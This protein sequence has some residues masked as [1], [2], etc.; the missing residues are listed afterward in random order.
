MGIFTKAVK[1]IVENQ[2]SKIK[3]S[4][5]INPLVKQ[6]EDIF[7][8]PDQVGDPMLDDTISLLSETNQKYV[9]EEKIGLEK[10]EIVGRLYSPV[11]S[12]IENM[13]IGKGGTKGEN[14][15]AYLRKRAPNV[16]KTE[17]ESFDINLDPKRLYTKEEVLDLAKEKGSTD[18]TIEKQ[19]FPE[20]R[21]SQRQDVMD[22][23]ED[24]LELTVEGKQKY[25]ESSSAVHLGRKSNIGHSRSSIR[26][27]APTQLQQKIIDRPRYLLIEEIQSDLAKRRGKDGYIEGIEF[28]PDEEDYDE[29]ILSFDNESMYTGINYNVY[30]DSNVEEIIRLEITNNFSPFNVNTVDDIKLI[31]E[32][33]TYIGLFKD[34]IEKQTGKRP[35]GNTLIKAARNALIDSSDFSDAKVDDALVNAQGSADPE[36]Q[37]VNDI[38]RLFNELPEKLV[39]VYSGQKEN[40]ASIQKIPVDSRSGYVR[41]LILA[42]IA[43]AKRNG[44]DKIVIPN[45]R[46]IAKM[47]IET[48]DSVLASD[49]Q[50]FKAYEKARKKKGF[51]YDEYAADYFEK[52]FKPLYKDSVTKVLN[53]L[54]S[55][56]K[57]KIKYGTKELKYRGP[58]KEDAQG[59]LTNTRLPYKADAIEIDITDFE[60]NP[61]AQSLRFNEGGAVSMQEQMKLFNEGGLKDEGGSV[62]PVSGNDV[63]IGS[64]QE[65]VRDDIP[66]MLS[67]G[68]FVFPADVVR[69]L[70]LERLMQLRQE[71]KMGL[72]QMEAMG[73]M[74]NSEEATMPDDLPFNMADLI[75][76]AGEG[77]EPKEMAQGG[78][79]HMSNGG[80]LPKFVDQGVETAPINIESF[81]TTLPDPDFSNVKKYVNKEGKVRFIP[82]GP[83]GKPLYPI[84]VGFFPEGELPED[85]PTETEEAIPTTPTGGG[86]GS[87]QTRFSPFQEAGSWNM[88]TSTEAGMQMW[89]DEANKISTFGNIG[90]GVVAA[91]NPM[92]GAAFAGFN[93]MQKNKVISMLDDKIGSAQSQAQIDELNKIKTRLTTKEGKGIIAQAISGFIKPIAEALGIGEKEEVVKKVIEVT[94]NDEGKSSDDIKTEVE[95]VSK[96]AF[97]SGRLDIDT[98]P[99]AE[100][101][102]SAFPS[103]RLD[104][105]TP[106]PVSES[107]APPVDRSGAQTGLP[108]VDTRQNLISDRSGIQTGL[109]RT[110]APKADEVFDPTVQSQSVRDE[111][112]QT[113]AYSGSGYKGY[114]QINEGIIKP[115]AN[116]LQINERGTTNAYESLM[117]FI[118][119]YTS[120]APELSSLIAQ[121]QRAEDS[122]ANLDFTGTMQP[123]SGQDL[124][125]EGDIERYLSSVSDD[126]PKK[127]TSAKD[128][129]DRRQNQ[130]RFK[131]AATKALREDAIGGGSF[132]V[133]KDAYDSGAS[134]ERLQSIAKEDKKIKEKLKDMEKGI[135]TGFAKGGLASR[136]K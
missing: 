34:R 119:Q 111:G 91:L 3:P 96:S 94:N 128:R 6:T 72:K 39:K 50:L 20:Y 135:I 61:E 43:Y 41:K 121:K 62:D 110:I 84:P 55:E 129:R 19:Q 46:E 131:D 136:T 87:R 45:P 77:E 118:K 69:Y 71:A 98:P 86:G 81:D 14:I 97:P 59:R 35:E 134:S 92:L 13:A 51:N 108:R 64:T 25:T 76:V 38:D 93:K 104:I 67:E 78:V 8:S 58:Y 29:L 57:G 124:P 120:D 10:E 123:F 68:E 133:F 48:F 47:R 102:K 18:Y 32:D 122:D 33:E 112:L 105:D 42:N 40:T 85:T 65:E 2:T 36:G 5:D 7:K 4:K 80:Y 130:K 126:K 31:N 132:K 17:L 56:T 107:K 63:P 99:Q 26:R 117:N 100:D 15:S 44:I 113:E 95:Q 127:D 73:Q 54:K 37:F 115:L 83:D 101:S 89:I 74:G 16:D 60:F 1:N 9:D 90:T 24:Y 52:I 88:D 70:G 11:Y 30:T 53:T 125:T 12:A 66:A 116:A 114:D 28:N 103:G 82:F 106:P 75:I 22:A 49:Q 23:E 27:E 79:V 109:E 21:D